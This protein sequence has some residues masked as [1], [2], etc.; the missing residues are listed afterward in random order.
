MDPYF[1]RLGVSAPTDAWER[2][3]VL[4]WKRKIQSSYEGVGNKIAEKKLTGNHV[5]AQFESH[6]RLLIPPGKE[7]EAVQGGT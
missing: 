7:R 6:Q 3:P 2:A 5:Q 1:P 4:A